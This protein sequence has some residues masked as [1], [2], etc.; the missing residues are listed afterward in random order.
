MAI[1]DTT[2]LW[3]DSGP[4]PSFPP[5]DRDLKVDVVVVGGGI[6]G[7]TTAYLMKQ[8]GLTV[9][10]L[11]REHLAGG[12]TGFTTAHL[13]AV[14]DL[15]LHEVIKNF[16]EQVA[17]ALWD[18]GGAAIDEIVKLTRECGA[19]SGFRWVPGY[20]HAPLGDEAGEVMS[21]L[22]K[23]AGAARQLGIPVSRVGEVP[24]GRKAGL[25]FP[26]Q[27]LF[28][29][30]RHLAGLLG[31]IPG[32]GSHVHERTAVTEVT[33][34]PLAVKAGDHT[35][36]CDY[37]VL[38]THNPLMGHTRLMKALLFQTKLAL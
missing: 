37:V 33:E 14:T 25:K 34:Q 13:T 27:A 11:E 32:G 1:P 20:L 7:V 22:E 3:I 12:D 19:N 9:A 31:R 35:V 15:R 16:D 10:L 8:A 17:R 38:A 28:H 2:S 21:E 4:L 26:Q 18:A 36:Q 6:T 29:P 30:R 23:E 24:F 5:L